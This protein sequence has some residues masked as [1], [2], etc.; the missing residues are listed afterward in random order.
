MVHLP[1]D[2]HILASF[3]NANLPWWKALAELVDN[4]LDAGATR[5]VIDVT[6]RVVTVSD[7][8]LG[9]EDIT[10]V[11]KLGEHKRRKSSKRSLGRYGI[12]A[13][14]AWLSCADTMEVTSFRGNTKTTMRVNYT[15]WMQNNW[16]V[17]DPIVEPHSGP[18]GTVI[19]LPLRPGKKSPAEEAF[20]SI[21]FAFTPA[22][23]S[24]IQIVRQS[25]T[26]K[27]TLVPVTMPLRNDVVQAEF[28]IDG[29]SVAIDIGILPDGVSLE[30]GPFWLIYGHRIIDVSSIGAGQYS[31]RRVA[32]TITIGDGWGLSKNKDDLTDNLDRLADAIF[33][34]IEHVLKKADQLAETIESAMLKNEIQDMINSAA[35]DANGKTKAKRGPGS[36]SGT[37]QPKLTDRNHKACATQ[38]GDGSIDGSSAGQ[39]SGRKTGYTMD[40]ANLDPAIIGKFDPSGM[41]VYL[42]LDNGLIASAKDQSNRAAL[43]ACAVALIADHCCRHDDKGQKFLR[44]SFD[45]FPQ[46]MGTLVKD[47]KE[48]KQNAKAAV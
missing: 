7:D 42:N 46:A 16:N 32:G 47:Y 27:K 22:I 2:P 6:G 18:S 36:S 43:A 5:V 40:W 13:K 1:P 31:V 10:A 11:F 37:V 29:K 41:R 19:R 24:G 17:S 44:F 35:A 48:E 14:D 45:D 25:G 38:P 15:D 34:R 8:G 9:C 12:G 39:G 3:A 4:S 20:R 26:I 30:R 33:V 23:S 21:A 28:D